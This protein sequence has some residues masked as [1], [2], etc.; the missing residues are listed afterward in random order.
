MLKL[1]THTT[2]QYLRIIYKNSSLG[3]T[4]LYLGG[5]PTTS[6]NLWYLGS[7]DK[8]FRICR[9]SDVDQDLG[10][11]I[12][13]TDDALSFN[14]DTISPFTDRVQCGTLTLLSG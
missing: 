1:I 4:W 2:N 8:S 12:S 7:E 5:S 13:Y 10:L 6:A 9:G 11:F 14:N 3:S